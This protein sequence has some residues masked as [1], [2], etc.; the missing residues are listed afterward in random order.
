VLII[1]DSPEKVRQHY[2]NH[3]QLTPFEGQASD[4][5]LLDVIPF[6]EWL[7]DRDDF[8]RI[9]K[10]GWRRASLEGDA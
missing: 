3:L 6:L 10:R 4:R 2:G 7:K 9:E 5:D 8:R 1:D